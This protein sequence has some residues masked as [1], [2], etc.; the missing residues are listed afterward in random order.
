[1][2][3]LF[4]FVV[5]EKELIKKQ[6]SQYTGLHS[7]LLFGHEIRIDEE[8]HHSEEAQS[9]TVTPL[10]PMYSVEMPRGNLN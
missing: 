9:R 10:H 7:N 8:F 6:S 2:R 4:W 1:M 3:M 5:A